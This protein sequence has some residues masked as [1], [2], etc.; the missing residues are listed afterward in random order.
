MNLET[1]SERG[2]MSGCDTASEIDAD[3]IKPTPQGFMLSGSVIQEL[4]SSG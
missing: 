2:E 4:I 1:V 3:G